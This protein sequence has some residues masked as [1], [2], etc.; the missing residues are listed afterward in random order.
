MSEQIK[1]TEKELQ[2]LQYVKDN[3]GIDVP[4]SPRML[5]QNQNFHIRTAKMEY[6]GFLVS[7]YNSGRMKTY[8]LT[9][10]G[11][12]RLELENKDRFAYSDDEDRQLIFSLIERS[13]I[14]ERLKRELLRKIQ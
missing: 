12:T 9:P 5:G 1:L 3:G 4:L 13:A 11:N 7:V 10:L 8:Y 6:H 14:S 2:I